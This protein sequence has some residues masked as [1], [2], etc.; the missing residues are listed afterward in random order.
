VVYAKRDVK[1]YECVPHKISIKMT[2]RGYND[3]WTLNDG[4]KWSHDLI[5]V[6]FFGFVYTGFVI[7]IMSVMQNKVQTCTLSLILK[8]V[9]F[10]F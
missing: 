5:V 1:L 9:L 4:H 3:K 10:K 6:Q 8:M 7:Y 2:K